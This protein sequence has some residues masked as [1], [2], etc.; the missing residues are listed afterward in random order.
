VHGGAAQLKRED[1]PGSGADAAPRVS[2]IVRSTNRPSLATAL[3]SIAAQ[4][5]PALEVVV[6]GASGAGHPLPPDHAGPHPLR[7]A[8][9]AQPLTRPRAANAGLDAAQGDWITFL[10]DDDRLLAG[11]IAGLVAAR[12]R[13]APA[14]LVYT[15]ALARMADGGTQTWGRPYALQQLYERNFI[16]LATALFSRRLLVLGCRFDETFEIMQDWDF[17][18]QCAQH[19]AFHFEPRRTFEWRADRGSSGAGGGP[20]HDPARFAAFRD[21]IYAKWA[22]EH[23]ALV[24]RVRGDLQ[25]AMLRARD[26]DAQGAENACRAILGYSQNDPHVLNALAMLHRGAGRHGEARAI[27][28]LACAVNPDDPSLVYNLALVCRLQGDFVRARACCRRVVQAAPTFAPAQKL[29]A[30]LGG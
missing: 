3:E 20:N 27:Q 26:G 21:R 2:I 28:E 10:D 14:L 4:D 7:F 30:E 12:A 29:L 13:A 23:D 16:H 9:S 17:F 24:E 6:V 25:Q 18:L 11:H 1:P 8:A 15:L 5:Y 22:R 19:T